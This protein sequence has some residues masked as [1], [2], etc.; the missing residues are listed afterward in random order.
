LSDTAAYLHFSSERFVIF[1]CLTVPNLAFHLAFP[2]P[3]M[4]Q[5]RTWT[6][7]QEANKPS[8]VCSVCKAV[9]QLHLKDNTVHRH[10]PRNN[11][12][13]GSDKPP[14]TMSNV[15]PGQRPAT[16]TVLNAPAGP[17]SP[18]LTVSNIPAGQ[19]AAAPIMPNSPPAQPTVSSTSSGQPYFSYARPTAPLLKHIPRSARPACCTHFSKT[20]RCVTSHPDDLTAWRNLLESGMKLLSI[21]HRG[22]K[23]HNLANIIKSR[24]SA[25]PDKCYADT[26]LPAMARGLSVRRVS[27]DSET[28]LASAVSGK[29]ED[30][31]LKAAIRLMC[32]DDK[33]ATA[34]ADTVAK[35]IEKHPSPPADRRAF[36]SATSTQLLQVSD[37]DVS[38]AL[39]SFPCGSSGGPDG[40][41]PQHL[42]DLINCVES[43]SELLSSI[44]AFINLLLVGHCNSA[45]TPHLFGG[46][47]Y[48]LEKKSGGIRPIAVGF[49]WRR[50]AA[51]CANGFAVTKLSNM[52]SPLQ[53]GIGVRGG[54]EAAVHATRRFLAQ[55]QDGEVVA[56]LD[57]S[58]AFNTLRRDD[59][60]D[61]VATHIPEIL[62]FCLLS[63]ST[64]SH[65][66]FDNHI[67]TSSEG[68]QQGDP[69][70]PFLFCITLHPILSS[71]SSKLTL[72]YLDDITIGGMMDTVADDIDL[73]RS[74]GERL[75]LNLNAKKCEVIYS[76]PPPSRHTFSEFIHLS[77]ESSTLLGAPLIPGRAMD[78]ALNS[79][80]AD[81][82]RAMGRL[83]KISAHDAL[84]ILRS[85]LSAP[86]I[87]YTI[88]SAPCTGHPALVA[89]DNLLRSAISAITNNPLPEIGW[90]Q[91][92][93]PVAEGGLGIRSVASLAPSAFLASAAGTR[94]LQDAILLRCITSEDKFIQPALAAWQLGHSDIPP[95]GASAVFQSK[96]DRSTITCARDRLWLANT[97]QHNRARLLATA[98]PHSGDW[99]HALP[100]TACGLRMDDEAIR[101]AVGL[102]LGVS[103]CEPH[104]CP[105]GALVDTL[106]AHGLSCRRSAGRTV[107]HQQ[108]NDLVWRALTRANIP[109]TKE[110]V[111]LSRSDGKRPDGLTLIPWKSGKGLIWDVTV[112][113]TL[114]PSYLADTSSTPGSAA[115]KAATKKITKYTELARTHLFCPLAWESMGPANEQGLSFIKELG[116]R[117]STVTGDPREAAFLF[118]RISIT[119]QRCNS[120]CFSGTFCQPPPFP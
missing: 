73:V 97:D 37:E 106:G 92:S 26:H 116:Q 63:Y 27:K 90:I 71:L 77:H 119:L 2:I 120:I 104:N 66:L 30:G 39:R 89:F 52:L 25:F 105:C 6:L 57:F 62:H 74:A 54:C 67:I 69:L 55:I 48:A 29:I 23:R 60:L 47:L 82:R 9:R 51:K 78:D 80:C 45:V 7:S 114:A 70:G 56:K 107:R 96:W 5:P 24:I 46:T 41:R 43:G 94:N 99:L 108:I 14:L 8:G 103:I 21:P 10:G 64:P 35:L 20:L 53:L 86:K 65:L 12:C 72:G 88:R 11:P 84:T 115:E 15:P 68:V 79:R 109:A 83:S 31:N 81:L 93:L 1:F 117:I 28:R 3:H 87:L 13:A 75:G 40:L 111:G 95:T 112:A 50:L 113:D 32:S 42:L 102:R 22:G 110:P 38:K 91:A 36:P 101:V 118:Q 18:T 85:S 61:A 16:P 59:I 17:L 100:I 4:S 58:N 98:A 76:G 44:T 33:P 49:T 34:S 19:P